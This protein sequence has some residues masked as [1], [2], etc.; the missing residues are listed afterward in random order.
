VEVPAAGAVELATLLSFASEG[1]GDC[2]AASVGMME[3]GDESA[4]VEGRESR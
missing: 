2:A 1:A 4:E 3:V